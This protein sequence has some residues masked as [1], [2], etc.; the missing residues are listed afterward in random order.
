MLQTKNGYSSPKVEGKFPC[1]S[2]IKELTSFSFKYYLPIKRRQPRRRIGIIDVLLL[3]SFLC[4][5]CVNGINWNHN[6]QIIQP[7]CQLLRIHNNNEPHLL[8]L[9]KPIDAIIGIRGGWSQKN[10]ETNN[11]TQKSKD[12]IKSSAKKSL[13]KVNGNVDSSTSPPLNLIRFLFLSFY[14]SLG[15]LLPFLP[16]YYHSLGHDGLS[17][18]LLGSV[19][20]LTTFLVAPIW[21]IISDQSNSPHFILQLTFLSGL[22]LQLSCAMNNNLS[23]LICTVFLCSVMSAPIKS[24][25]DCMVMNSLPSQSKGEYGKLRLWGQLGFGLGSSLVG[26]S[27]NHIPKTSAVDVYVEKGDMWEIVRKFWWS[28]T[29]GYKLAFVSHALISI[30]CFICKYI[31]LYLHFVFL[32]FCMPSYFLN[33]FIKK[34]MKSLQRYDVESSNEIVVQ[35]KASKVKNNK[36]QKQSK[37]NILHGINLLLHNPD[38]ILFFFLVFVIG[39]SSGIIEN[40]AYVRMR[41]VGG[42]GRE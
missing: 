35:K 3:L 37:T 9:R 32:P 5:K 27:L 29:H 28:I 18:G 4:L 10:K 13:E 19:K 25:M 12:K 39:V 40:F 2:S 20:P 41:E 36:K 6:H 22:L 16:V 14:A 34:G 11:P 23:W 7:N 1:S 33:C 8:R 26:I 31:C 38:A 15:S 24:L 42:T 30:P 21:G 17:I